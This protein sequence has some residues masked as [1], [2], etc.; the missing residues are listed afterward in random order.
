MNTPTDMDIEPSVNNENKAGRSGDTAPYF[1]DETITYVCADGFGTVPALT[2][3]IATC[4]TAG[5]NPAIP[6]GWTGPA[7]ADTVCKPGKNYIF[8]LLLHLIFA[9]RAQNR[10]E[11]C[12]DCRG[13]RLN[14]IV[15]SNNLCFTQ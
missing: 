2:P 7:N 15:M 10:I 5:M 6:G 9:K 3:I 14:K 8:F 11:S 4:D 1:D 12:I 13:F